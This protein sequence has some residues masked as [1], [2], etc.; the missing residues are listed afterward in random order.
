MGN[1]HQNFPID[2]FADQP[3]LPPGTHLNPWQW[4]ALAVL[5]LSFL[6][7]ALWALS[8]LPT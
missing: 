6:A 4:V 3:L 1:E 8:G 2:P 5:G 7:L